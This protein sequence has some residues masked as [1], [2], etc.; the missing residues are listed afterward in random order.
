[1]SHYLYSFIKRILIRIF[2]FYSF[3]RKDY[4][5]SFL[6]LA[7]LNYFPSVKMGSLLVKEVR[8]FTNSVGNSRSKLYHSLCLRRRDISSFYFEDG[9]IETHWI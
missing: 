1:M 3:M 4:W 2:N 6:Y 5:L 8:L 9:E 7:S